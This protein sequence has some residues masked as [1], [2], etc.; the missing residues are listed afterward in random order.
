EP[1]ELLPDDRAGR[2]RRRRGC[3]RRQG[4]R[5]D[6]SRA[7]SRQRRVSRDRSRQARLRARPLLR[8]PE[9]LTRKSAAPRDPRTSLAKALPAATGGTIDRRAFLRRSGLAAG[10]LAAASALPMAM[11]KKAESAAP[12]NATGPLKTIK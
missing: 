1:A 3:R 7:A 5:G 2:R 11:V 9:M 8:R 12:A 6:R 4:G 10:G